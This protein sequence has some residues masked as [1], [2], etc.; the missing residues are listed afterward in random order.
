MDTGSPIPPDNAGDGRP[1]IDRDALSALL[2]QE[3]K[4]RAGNP[5][6]VKVLS[7]SEIDAV[8]AECSKTSLD[9]KFLATAFKDVKD[10]RTAQAGR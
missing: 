4:P 1:T 8:V 9:A 6:Q 7:A 5:E 3:Y 10:Y 2:E